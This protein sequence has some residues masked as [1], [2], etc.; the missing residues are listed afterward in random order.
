MIGED[1]V[2]QL[3]ASDAMTEAPIAAGRKREC[4]RVEYN[5]HVLPKT[6]L[7]EKWHDAKCSA[8]H[9]FPNVPYYREIRLLAHRIRSSEADTCATFGAPAHARPGLS[10]L[11]GLMEKGFYGKRMT[12]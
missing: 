6:I 4:R 3:T 8:S 11:E 5:A 1:D 7:A 12:A 9:S 10:F 2:L